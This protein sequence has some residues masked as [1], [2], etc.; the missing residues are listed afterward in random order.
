M[1]SSAGALSDRFLRPWM[2]NQ[3]KSWGTSPP[4]TICQYSRPPT[5][6]PL[7]RSPVSWP[8]CLSG[9][10]VRENSQ[11][12]FPNCRLARRSPSL[13]AS[14]APQH[15]GSHV[16]KQRPNSINTLDSRYGPE[17]RGRSH[18]FLT[19]QT[20]LHCS[21]GLGL[22]WTSDSEFLQHNLHP[23]C[24]QP[25]KTQLRIWPCITFH[26]AKLRV[27]WYFGT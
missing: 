1:A 27:L 24:G 22:P 23:W 20:L 7:A 14:V 25:S 2:R 13:S 26:A 11:T 5:C 19:N 3:T 12:L 18:L 17:V 8:V 6:D 10:P 21:V 15:W 16:W 9:S 4:Y